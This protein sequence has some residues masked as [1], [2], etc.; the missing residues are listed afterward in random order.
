[1]TNAHEIITSLAA[2]ITEHSRGG[3]IDNTLED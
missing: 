1:M 2:V 3:I